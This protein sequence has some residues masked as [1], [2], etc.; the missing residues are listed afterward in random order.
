MKRIAIVGAGQSGLQLAFTLLDHGYHVTLATNRDA[1]QIR[2]GKVMSSQCM[3]HTALQLERDAGLNHWEEACP[4]IEGIGVAV[5]HPDG[6]GRKAID[7]SSRL[8]RYAQSVDQ[9][10]K[11]ADWLDAV[12]DRGADVRICDVGIAEL[13]ALAS[14][15]DL[16]LL[17]AGK[18]DIV[19]LLGRDDARSAFER[20]QRALALTYVKG[21]TPSQP[22]ARVRFNLLPGIG[23]YFVFPALTTTGPCEIMVFE[24]IP[25]GPLDC[26]ADVKTP[27]QHLDRGLSFLQRYVPWE[28]ERCRDVEL[29]D[30]NGTLAGRFTPTV[31][32]PLLRL[33]SG[34]TVFGMADAV[35]VNDPI[36]GQGSN[37]A[38]KCA[39]VYGDAILAREA[40]PFDEGWMHDTFERYWAYAQH[41]VRWTNSLLT[42]PPPHV[43]EL[44]GAAGQY[45]TLA[46]T[47]V[48]G[49]D[50]PRR[51]APWW[52]EPAA[53]AAMIRE[54]A[55]RSEQAR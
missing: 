35:V 26:W 12:R 20:P 33:P 42:P 25:G 3:F 19:N 51:F 53:C 23:E 21:M 43:L 31:R 1:Q 14:S 37:N 11:M 29:T 10:V 6:G 38:A 7:W 5:P 24:G 48:D 45:P 49:F 41:V 54:H 18:G 22:Y 40:A 44:L 55:A 47:L 15:H 13:E 17:A 52:F 2:S 9:R 46:G 32:K 28:F 4:S 39:K 27:E 36:T 50:D 8:T 16:V 34:R 30:P